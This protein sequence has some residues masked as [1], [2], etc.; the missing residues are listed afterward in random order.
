MTSKVLSLALA[1]VLGGNVQ[2]DDNLACNDVA[3]PDMATASNPS[4]GPEDHSD[5]LSD[6]V[7]GIDEAIE[8]MRDAGYPEDHPELKGLMRA[9]QVRERRQRNLTV[10]TY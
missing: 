1:R 6:D 5:A 7:R 9:K 2:P 3:Q 4:T 10:R 8:R